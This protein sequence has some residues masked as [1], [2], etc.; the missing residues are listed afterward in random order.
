ME[1][2]HFQGENDKKMTKEEIYKDII[3]KSKQYKYEKQK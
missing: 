2:Y 1:K 3:K